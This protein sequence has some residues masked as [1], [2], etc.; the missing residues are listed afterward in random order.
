MDN[1][2]GLLSS[3][4]K[5]AIA[6]YRVSSFDIKDLYNL[7]DKR[8]EESRE[9]VMHVSPYMNAVF[10]N[11]K[12]QIAFFE[13]A[14]RINTFKYL[15]SLIMA[16]G[17]KK[18]KVFAW[19][20]KKKRSENINENSWTITE[21]KYNTWKYFD[22]HKGEMDTIF[23]AVKLSGSKFS[24]KIFADDSDG[25]GGYKYEKTLSENIS[26]NSIINQIKYFSKKLENGAY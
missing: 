3:I 12:D 8:H 9:Y 18:A 11:D 1:P 20:N 6:E 7:F 17:T 19:L 26:F 10:K 2:N 16:Y 13:K 21:E 15:R 25:Y 23:L 22:I 24:I 5:N 14:F 4:N